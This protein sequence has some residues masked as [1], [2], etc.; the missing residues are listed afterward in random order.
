[1]N[2]RSFFAAIGAFL[3]ALFAP[4][5]ALC[6]ETWPKPIPQVTACSW[7]EG[8][9]TF[10]KFWP[11]PGEIQIQVMDP[12]VHDLDWPTGMIQRKVM[13]MEEFNKIYIEPRLEYEYQQ[14]LN[15]INGKVWG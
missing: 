12:I 7:M 5:K 6:A 15:F 2:R 13:S 9:H 4:K 14:D 3:A 10:Y 11:N 1:M 8:G